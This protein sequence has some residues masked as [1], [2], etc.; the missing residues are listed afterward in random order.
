MSWGAQKV[1][2]SA[3]LPLDMLGDVQEV[4]P[5]AGLLVICVEW[6]LGKASIKVQ[7]VIAP[8]RLPVRCEKTS[9]E[10]NIHQAQEDF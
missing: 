4:H 2:P 6:S 3:Q 7:E 5:S 9:P 8:A 1:H 10:K